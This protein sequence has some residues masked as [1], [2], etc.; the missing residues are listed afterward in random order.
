MN[1]QQSVFV[2][3]PGNGDDPRAWPSLSPEQFDFLSVSEIA[4][5]T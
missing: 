3:N 1:P 4:S 2:L 5:T